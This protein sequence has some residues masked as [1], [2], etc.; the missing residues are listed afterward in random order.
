MADSS[1]VITEAVDKFEKL[2]TGGKVAVVSITAAVA[3]GGIIVANKRASASSGTSSGST[4]AAGTTTLNGGTPYDPSQLFSSSGLF[5][6]PGT[7]DT[8]TANGTGTTSSTTTPTP[9]PSQSGGIPLPSPT[10]TAG[11]SNN[12]HVIA[13]GSATPFKTL[14][15][16]I[17]YANGGK[18]TGTWNGSTVYNYRNNSQIFQALGLTPNQLNTPISAASVQISI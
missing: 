7:T 14:A 6:T 8:L 1:N 5:G 17:K 10:G 15:D 16:I 11:Q 12:Y 18:K 2:P 3:I 13:V 9:S 4:T